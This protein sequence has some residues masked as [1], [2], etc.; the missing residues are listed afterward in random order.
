LTEDVGG[1]YLIAIERD[2]DGGAHFIPD[3]NGFLSAAGGR[4]SHS[5]LSTELD[6]DLAASQGW[7]SPERRF[8]GAAA[9]SSLDLA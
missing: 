8:H 3:L 9:H 5:C 2:G 1:E 4:V 6:L 7:I